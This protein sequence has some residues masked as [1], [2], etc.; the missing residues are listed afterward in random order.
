MATTSDSPQIARGVRRRVADATP[1]VAGLTGEIS[2][3]SDADLVSAVE[4]V[5]ALVR[6]VDALK[7]RVAG[8]VDVRSDPLD[9]DRV[10]DDRLAIAFGCRNATELLERTTRASVPELRSRVRLDRRTRD[11]HHLMTGESTTRYPIVAQAFRDGAIGIDIAR[12]L[13]DELDH[14]SK[15]HHIDP[16]EKRTAEREIIG[17]TVAGLTGAESA[18]ECDDALPSTFDEYRTVAQVWIEFL[19]RDG[20]EPDDDWQARRR[21]FSLG[22]ARNGLVPVRGDLIPEVAAGIQRLFDAYAGSRT[23][24][25]PGTPEPGTDQSTPWNGDEKYDDPRTAIQRNHDVLGSIVQAAARSADAPRS[26]AR[27]RH[28]S[29]RRRSAISTAASSMSTAW[30]SPHLHALPTASSAR[31]RFRKWFSTATVASFRSATASACST[32]TS[33]EPSP[34]A[35][36]DASSPAVRFRLGG[37]RS[38]TWTST[39]TAARPTPITACCCVGITTTTSKAPGGASACAMACPS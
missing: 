36:A 32:L 26:A 28:S 11:R 12:H 7:V 35:T 1:L 2:S 27:P 31:V 6:Q 8:E 3:L 30:T 21:G 16:D 13:T 39:L 5:E 18:S 4:E 17:A 14:A 38:T 15:T 33:A 10:G 9:G 23:L 19:T 20:V 24:F 34:P 22:R 25:A 29:S 37:A